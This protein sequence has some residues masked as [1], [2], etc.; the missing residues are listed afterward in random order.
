MQRV[1]YA[2]TGQ[3]CHHENRSQPVKSRGSGFVCSFSSGNQCLRS[4]ATLLPMPHQSRFFF[5]ITAA[6]AA[7]AAIS[8][9]QRSAAVKAAV[10]D[11]DVRVVLVAGRVPVVV[12]LWVPAFVRPALASVRALSALSTS[13]WVAL[14]RSRMASASFR[15][16]WKAYQLASV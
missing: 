5:Q 13:S 12:P 9:V 8:P 15:A 3:C 4:L 11:P 14:S 1:R 16:L 6:A 10:F 7:A 2:Y